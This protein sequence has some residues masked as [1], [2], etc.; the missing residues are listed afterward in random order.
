MPED[1]IPIMRPWMDEEE[2]DAVR[3][4]IL[5]GWVTQGP[6]VAAFEQDFSAAVGARHACAVSSCTAALHLALQVLGVTEGDEVIAPSH[7]FIATANSIRYCG[8]TPVFVDIDPASY[9]LDPR[10]VAESIT[11]RTRAIVCVHQMGMPCD[12]AAILEIARDAGIPLIEDAACALG[13]LSLDGEQWTPIG[14]PRGAIACFSFHPRKLVTAGEG[15]MLTTNDPALHQRLRTLRQHGMSVPDAV[16]HASARAVVE[17]YDEVGYNYRMTDVQAAMGRV[18]LMRLPAIVERRRRLADHYRALLAGSPVQPPQE[19]AWARSNWQSFCVR[20]PHDVDQRAVMQ[21]ML[22]QGVATRRGILCAHL[23]P[24][25]DG[26]TWAAGAGGLEQ[27]ERAS[28]ECI[29][30]PLFHQLE[31]SDQQ[32]VVRTLLGGLQ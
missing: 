14:K 9:N 3:R 27:S 15:G 22:D 6:E 30:L 4:V 31:E 7:S 16:R 20:L 24:A 29:L 17:S 12:L 8:A 11:P 25:Y 28:R 13:S 5:S 18:Q 32:R 21:R 2:A 26:S 19:P 10:R 23:E 1:R